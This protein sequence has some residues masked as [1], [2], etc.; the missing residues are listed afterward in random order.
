MTAAA[1]TTPAAS[2]PARGGVGAA[3]VL[4]SAAG[5]GA[6]AIFGKLAYDAGVSTMTLLLVRFALGGLVFAALLARRRP[7]HRARPERRAVLTGLALGGIGYSTQAGL[8]FGALHRLDASLLALVLYTYP[9]WVTIAGI[10]I[11]RE[12]ADR[13]RLAALGLASAGLVIVL[14]GASGG[15]FDGL[16][17]AM[18]L[19]AALAYTAYIL[20]ADGTG[21]AADPLRLS[22]LV[23]AGATVT[24]TVAGVASGELDFGFQAEGW[25]W[26]AAIAVVSTAVPIATFFAGMARVGPSSAAILSTLEPVVTVT[27]AY[28]AFSEHLSATQL[29]GAVLVLSAAVLLAAMPRRRSD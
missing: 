24:F 10:A 6:M 11:G 23:C 3:L 27:L 20:V 1:P 7:Q 5:F 12:R 25:L 13:R 2:A 18:G 19:G 22:A 21:A 16:G 9:A 14:A 29:V 8:Y 28:L 15:S 4:V 26:L 17:A